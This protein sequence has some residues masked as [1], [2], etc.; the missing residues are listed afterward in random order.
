MSHR[1][2]VFFTRS[3]QRLFGRQV[4]TIR[5]GL[6]RG[7]KRRYGQGFRPRFKPTPEEQF[8]ESLDFTG[9]IVFDIG[10]Y[11]GLMTLFFARAVG[12]NGKV[13][14]FEPSPGN[15]AELVFNVQLNHFDHV[16]VFPVALGSTPGRCSMLLD[17][18]Y[19][20]RAS[21]S[22]EFQRRMFD[23]RARS[24]EV[25]VD[26]LDHQLQQHNLPAPDF[27]KIDVEGFE[28]A[29]LSG[30]AET[31]ARCRPQLFIEVHGVWPRALL[32]YLAACGYTCWRVESQ[33][34]MTADHLPMVR[35][36]HL[37]A[38]PGH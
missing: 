38:T 35:G 23:Q 33:M 7:L 28:Q 13:I 27:V 5:R 34:A 8:L 32:E 15:Y 18:M 29:V 2:T 31:L 26:T 22:E 37:F 3:A 19:P 16:T 9:K 30:M 20:S 1:A 17:P 21:L 14:T 4:Y 10:G 11:V 25:E 24:I 36:G 6:A 12:R